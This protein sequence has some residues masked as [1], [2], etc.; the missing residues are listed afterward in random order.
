VLFGAYEA[1]LTRAGFLPMGGQIVALQRLL[2]LA[3][4]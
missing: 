2:G 3:S 1:A 4:L